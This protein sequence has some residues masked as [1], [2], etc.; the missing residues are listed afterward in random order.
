MV[1]LAVLG[2]EMGLGKGG[3]PLRP[4]GGEG[5]F[6]TFLFAPSSFP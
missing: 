3:M 6:Q 1:A 2:L 4:G 5:L